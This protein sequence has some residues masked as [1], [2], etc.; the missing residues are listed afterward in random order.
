MLF[1][2]NDASINSATGENNNFSLDAGTSSITFNEDL[3]AIRAL[4]T[5]TINEADAGVIFGGADNEVVG[6]G[7]TGPVNVI[8][9]TGD[10]NIGVATN[11]ITGTGIVLN[12]GSSP[13]VITTTNANVR[14]N[15]AVTLASDVRI[16]TGSGTGDITFTNDTPVDS[17]ANEFNDL[18]LTAGSGIIRFNEDIGA[19]TNGQLGAF[20]IETA[21]RVLFGESNT[22]TAGTGSTGPVTLIRTTDTINIGSL[23]V[24]KIGRAHV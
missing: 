16:D 19:A 13:L 3:G 14:L 4:G 24:I 20:T 21:A 5:F 8:N 22:E 23:A 12:G 7:S 6:T 15:G 9:T 10:I 17:S 2:S 11:V 18:T 1:R